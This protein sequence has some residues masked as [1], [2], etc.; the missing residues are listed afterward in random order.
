MKSRTP[1]VLSLIALLVALVMAGCG[2]S[3]DEKGGEAS[4]DSGE[5]TSELSLVAYSTPQ[6]VY[7]EIIP[8]FEKTPEGRGVGFKSSFGASGD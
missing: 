3:S 1:V 4:A 2:G 8:D 6:V 5:T 7:D